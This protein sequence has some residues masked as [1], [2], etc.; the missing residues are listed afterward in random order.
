MITPFIGTDAVTDLAG[1]RRADADAFAAVHAAWLEAGVFWPPSQ[2]ES[3]FLS[4]AHTESDIDHAVAVFGTALHTL[5]RSVAA[6][7]R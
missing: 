6:A 5:P 7:T 3:G 2:F 1:A 4:T